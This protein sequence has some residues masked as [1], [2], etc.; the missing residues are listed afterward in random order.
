MI[1]GPLERT[2]HGPRDAEPVVPAVSAAPPD[3]VLRA[4][5]APSAPPDLLEGG[6]GRTWRCGTIVF[7]PVDDPVEALWLANVFEQLQVPGVR[8]ARPVRSSDGRWVVSAWSAQRFVSGSPAPRHEEIL[9]ASIGLHEA[10]VSVPEPK[11]LRHRPGLHAWADRLAWGDIDDGEAR[12]GTGHGARLFA[13]LAADR[14][15]VE[16][17]SQVVHGDLYGN[18]L[19]AGLAPPA[20]VDI[21]PYWRPAGWSAGVIAVDAIAWGG[22]QVELV[23]ELGRW[24]ELEGHD[25]PQ[26]LRR[27]L[28]FRL[29]VSLANPATPPSHLVTMLSTAERIEPFLD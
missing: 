20:V 14:R 24:P 13:G 19:F 23:T 27:A 29:A 21:T 5:G 2:P 16:A 26:L 4:F 22:A 9:R 15:P 8:L 7:K 28:L 17:P 25:W 10:L 11:F 12:T 18:V 6:Q 1:G 3:H